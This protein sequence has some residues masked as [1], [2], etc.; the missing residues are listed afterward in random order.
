VNE[1][2]KPYFSV[3]IPTC[4]RPGVLARTFALFEPGQQHSLGGESLPEWEV[5]VT[6]DSANPAPQ[7]ALV[8]RCA[9]ARY[10][11]GP[12]RGA[13]MNRNAGAAAAMGEWVVF[14]DDDCVVRPDFLAHL[15]QCIA[16][17]GA[18]VIEGRIVCPQKTGWPWCSEPENLTGG[19]FW[20]GNL[21]VRREVF[22]ALGGFDPALGRGEDL[23]FAQ[24][25]L[26]RGLRTAFCEE[27]VA[28][29]PSELLSPR[30]YAARIL[31]SRWQLLVRL[32]MSPPR[33]GGA[34]WVTAG[35]AVL[36]C[37]LPVALRQSWIPWRDNWRQGSAPG[38]ALL[39]GSLLNLVYIPF[40]LPYMIYWERRY[41]QQLG[42]P[43]PDPGEKPS[44]VES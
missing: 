8:A 19:V 42:Q 28:L 6:D 32:K 3:V 14:L 40:L 38:V 22:R 13:G 24:L 17:T 16:T 23:Y 31:S 1:R 37:W 43:A 9:H 41:R 33:H 10:V 18:D 11:R 5:I 21:A 4:D 34:G 27:A 39:C 35:R 20:S 29:H 2:G 44:P 30:R 15:A 26:A 36:L 25:I 12:R 7:Q